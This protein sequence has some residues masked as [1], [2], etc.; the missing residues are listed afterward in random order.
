MRA[1][2]KI[3]L[4]GGVTVA[5][6]A[7]C[8]P[9]RKVERR[10]A[11]DRTFVEATVPRSPEAVAAALPSAFG[12]AARTTTADD[13]PP[14]GALRLYGI[15]DPVVPEEGQM[16]QRV[17]GNAALRRYLGLPTPAR[18]AD[19][20]LYEPTG[21]RY[22]HSEYHAGGAPVEFRCAFVIHVAPEGDGRTRV[23]VIEYLPM[24]RAGRKLG[25]SG[26][27]PLPG[28]M[29]DQRWVEPTTSDRE[30]VLAAIDAALR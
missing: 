11:H 2:A 20:Y 1:A 3:L 7:A 9:H 12:P 21:D 19:F 13:G 23:E 24:V 15:A 22:W 4:L 14:L 6:F 5:A 29:A 26:H 8:A 25:V 16:R 10:A 17:E 28:L 27:A 18:K 30:A